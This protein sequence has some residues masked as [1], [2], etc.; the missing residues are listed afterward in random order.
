MK[1]LLSIVIGSFVWF[2]LAKMVLRNFVVFSTAKGILISWCVT[3]LFVATVLEEI[4]GGFVTHNFKKEAKKIEGSWQLDDGDI[5]GVKA[6][7]SDGNIRKEDDNSYRIFIADISNNQGFWVVVYPELQT[8][9]FKSDGDFQETKYIY[10]IKWNKIE[11]VDQNTDQKILLKKKSKKADKFGTISRSY[12]KPEIKNPDQYYV[13]DSID[14]VQDYESQI[15]LINPICYTNTINSTAIKVNDSYVRLMQDDP[16]HLVGIGDIVNADRYILKGYYEHHGS[17]QYFYVQQLEKYNSERFEELAKD[18]IKETSEDDISSL[19]ED[20]EN[21]E[22][23]VISEED[24]SD[25]GGDNLY[26]D[27]EDNIINDDESDGY[28]YEYVYVDSNNIADNVG[29]KCEM[30]GTIVEVQGDYYICISG[31][32]L[33]LINNYEMVSSHNY[34]KLIVQ[35]MLGMTADDRYVIEIIDFQEES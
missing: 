9:L 11:L 31:D 5:W 1:L 28:G 8:F 14:K 29:H 2:L 25:N 16:Q 24:L 6:V 34:E 22:Q 21:I 17:D 19:E 35:C 33:V 4:N 20:S 15:V 23:P 7:D 10:K 3:V 12:V 30:N 13:L 32:L 18:G 26:D 27:S